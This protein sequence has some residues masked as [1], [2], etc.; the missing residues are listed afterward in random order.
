MFFLKKR[1]RVHAPLLPDDIILLTT[2]GLTE[3]IEEKRIEKL[4]VAYSDVNSTC[5][6]LLEEA[7]SIRNVDNITLIVISI[8]CDQS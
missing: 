6:M 3:A 7:I 1:Q 8:T 4:L 2:D 5:G